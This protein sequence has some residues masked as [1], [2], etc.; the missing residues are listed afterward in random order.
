M[1]QT[2]REEY[3]WNEILMVIMI[4]RIIKE[5]ILKIVSKSYCVI[6]EQSFVS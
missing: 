5:K 3:R 4:V 1:R 2:M 6:C